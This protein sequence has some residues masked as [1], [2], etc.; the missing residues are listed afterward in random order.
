MTP[1]T[2]QIIFHEIEKW[3]ATYHHV[4]H[5]KDVIEMKVNNGHSSLI[6]TNKLYYTCNGVPKHLIR[7]SVPYSLSAFDNT[8]QIR[9]EL[10]NFV[11]FLQKIDSDFDSEVEISKASCSEY[12]AV[13]AVFL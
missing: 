7:P 2:H 3:K 11:N 8:I 4:G 13:E 1:G 12:N 10:Q 9:Q 6:F 5:S